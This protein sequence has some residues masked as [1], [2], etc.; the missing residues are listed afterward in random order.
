MC[1]T[2]LN[3]KLLTSTPQCRQWR[4]ASDGVTQCQTKT[5]KQTLKLPRRRR[6]EPNLRLRR[7]FCSN[8]GPL[9]QNF[10]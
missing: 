6:N 3:V 7:R 10:R 1:D 5:P 4:W 2:D 9:T 8:G